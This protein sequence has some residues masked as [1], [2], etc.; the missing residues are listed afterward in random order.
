MNPGKIH[1]LSEPLHPQ[2]LF[3]EDAVETCESSKR[4]YLLFR[5]QTGNGRW[6]NRKLYGFRHSDL[7][8]EAPWLRFRPD[9]VILDAASNWPP[10]FSDAADF[11]KRV[12]SI[13]REKGSMTRAQA[14]STW[15]WLLTRLSFYFGKMATS[16]DD[17]ELLPW[18]TVDLAVT[19][20]G[21]N[22]VKKG[23]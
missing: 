4:Y 11:K 3:G 20:R 22:L 17:F 2:P 16:G 23:F 9:E 19:C 15:F 18:D 12:G 7:R 8:R 14:W 21:H 10:F 1:L 5:L 13:G 6:A